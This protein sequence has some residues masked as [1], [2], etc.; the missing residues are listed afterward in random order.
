MCPLASYNLGT[1]ELISAS[2]V[3]EIT[4]TDTAPRRLLAHNI[5]D[6]ADDVLTVAPQ[7]KLQKMDGHEFTGWLEGLSGSVSS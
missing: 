4:A 7:I 1:T 3:K 6:T 5:G 2:A